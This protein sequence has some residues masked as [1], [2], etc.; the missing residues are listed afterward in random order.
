MLQNQMVAPSTLIGICVFL[1]GLII[2]SFLN[3]C[4]VRIPEKKSIVMPA[5]AC[6]KCGTPIRPYDNI[7]VLSWLMLGGKCRACK[8]KIS[9]MYP[10]VELLTA[11][12]FWGCYLAFGPTPET[13]KWAIFSALM[14]VL[15]FTDLRERILPDVVNYTGFG[16]GLA[17]SLFTKPSDGTA[18]WLA[19]RLFDFPPPAPVVSIVDALLGAAFGSGVLWLVSEVYFRLRGREGMGLGD[20]KMMLMAGAFLGL[21][22][23][24]LTILAGSVL[25]SLLGIV[26][27]LA[28]RKDSNYEL[29]FGTFLGMAALLVVFF[30]TPLV[31]WYASL[32]MVR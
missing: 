3:V 4:I 15:V 11:L 10:V 2:G 5:S 16:L 30:G 14:I 20:V 28:R 12:L 32:L 27:I 7:P 22:R 29:P 8:A 24:L 18:L 21:Q 9:W 26:F 13:L 23:T 31:N 25:G 17:L 19:N 1:F 6:P